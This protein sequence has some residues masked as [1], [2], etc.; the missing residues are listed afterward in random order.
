MNS[1][2][3]ESIACLKASRRRK[4]S[5]PSR[6]IPD[7]SLISDLPGAGHDSPHHPTINGSAIHERKVAD[8][9]GNGTLDLRDQ[10]LQRHSFTNFRGT[11]GWRV[12][13]ATAPISHGVGFEEVWSIPRHSRRQRFT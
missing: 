12:F 11:P 4:N 7:Q 5:V 8:L 3:I 6:S 13:R 1:G 9:D 10:T 2:N